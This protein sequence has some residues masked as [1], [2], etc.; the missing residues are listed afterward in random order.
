MKYGP[1]VGVCEG[2]PNEMGQHSHQDRYDNQREAR[3]SSESKLACIGEQFALEAV[4]QQLHERRLHEF[5]EEPKGNKR[6]RESKEKDAG[7][8]MAVPAFG[9][10]TQ[11]VL[12]VGRHRADDQSRP[13]EPRVA[14]RKS[15]GSMSGRERHGFEESLILRPGGMKIWDRYR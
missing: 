15:C 13:D 9:R 6:Q 4:W 5:V 7:H 10:E 12:K 3:R 8:S 11:E 2:I 14:E 1:S